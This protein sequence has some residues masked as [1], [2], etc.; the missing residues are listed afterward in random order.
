[1]ANPNSSIS[2]EKEIWYLG[3]VAKI[4]AAQIGDQLQPHISRINQK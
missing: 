3:G 2:P 4:D 1:M